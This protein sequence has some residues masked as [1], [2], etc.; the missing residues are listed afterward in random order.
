VP[1]RAA[2]A[3]VVVAAIILGAVIV[4]APLFLIALNIATLQKEIRWVFDLWQEHD[5]RWR[6]Q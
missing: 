3:A 6:R 1:H 4:A 2:R 5:T